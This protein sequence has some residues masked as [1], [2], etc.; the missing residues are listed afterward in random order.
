MQK[1]YSLSTRKE[2]LIWVD[3]QIRCDKLHNQEKKLNLI[4][5]KDLIIYRIISSRKK[6]ISKRMND[7]TFTNSSKS[8]ILKYL[9]SIKN[10]NVIRHHR[11]FKNLYLSLWELI[12]AIDFDIFAN[13]VEHNICCII[14]S[15]VLRKKMHFVSIDKSNNVRLHEIAMTS[16][17]ICDSFFVTIKTWKISRKIVIRIKWIKIFRS[18][19]IVIK[20]WSID[21]VMNHK[22]IKRYEIISKTYENFSK[23]KRVINI[24]NDFFQKICCL[25]T[26]EI[27]NDHNLKSRSF[28]FLKLSIFI[29]FFVN[30]THWISCYSI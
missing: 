26:I 16:S 8:K 21:W 13:F 5:L 25:S 11:T 22:F 10:E 2:W 17:I 27:K 20:L 18:W 6:N 1:R 4:F 9:L 28:K 7:K 30:Q 14:L 23:D 3:F 12:I 29:F 15:C 19:M 24:Y